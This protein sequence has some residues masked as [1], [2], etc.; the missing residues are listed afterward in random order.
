MT[1]LK[2]AET[3]AANLARGTRTTRWVIR[4]ER[5]FVPIAPVL[6]ELAEAVLKQWLPAIDCEFL[7]E[8]DTTGRKVS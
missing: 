3:L 1:D 6:G 4:G 8:Y 7:G 5:Y 2:K